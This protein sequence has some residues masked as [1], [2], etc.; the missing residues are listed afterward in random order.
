LGGESCRVRA[1]WDKLVFYKSMV[2]DNERVAPTGNVIGR[3][4]QAAYIIVPIL[5]LPP[6]DGNLAKSYIS[7]LGIWVPNNTRNSSAIVSCQQYRRIIETLLDGY[8]E[9]LLLDPRV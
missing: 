6:K 3:L 8:T 5:V 4:E 7:Q 2:L 1:T 9:R